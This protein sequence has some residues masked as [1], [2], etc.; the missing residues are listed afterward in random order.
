MLKASVIGYGYWGP[1]LARN[2][3]ND[4]EIQLKWIVDSSSERLRKAFL[5]YPFVNLSTN[6]SDVLND[7]EINIVAIATPVA[8]HFKLA[9]DAL[10]AGKHVWVEKPLASSAKEAEEL[11]KIA[12]KNDRILIVDHTFV[13]TGAVQKIKELIDKGEIGEVI[14]YDS[15]RVNLGLFQTDVNVIWDLAVH[16]I[17]IIDFIFNGIKVK[18]IMSV[19]MTYANHLKESLASINLVLRD[20]KYIHINVSWISPVKIRLALIGGSKKMIVYDDTEASE[21]I[22]VYDRGVEVVQSPEDL[23]KIWVQYRTGDMWAPKLDNRE[24][25]AVEVD[26]FVDCIKNGKK[27]ITDGL[28]GLKVVEVLE[29]IDRSL[30]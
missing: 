7:D 28:A 26:H 27:P 22:K 20:N 3:N 18:K 5:S 25:L 4:P 24:A 16:D 2:F 12:E 23:Y 17:S 6:V 1:N 11:V 15:I 9:K 19:G 30:R 21:K 10:E 29:M 14:Y 13:Y 8:T